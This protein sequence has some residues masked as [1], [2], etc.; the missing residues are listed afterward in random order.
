MVSVGGEVGIGVAS[1]RTEV[2]LQGLFLL[3]Q[4]AFVSLVLIQSHNDNSLTGDGNDFMVTVQDKV[5]GW[6]EC[7]SLF[8]V[9]PSQASVDTLTGPS[10]FN[11][12][13]SF[14]TSA[15]FGGGNPSQL[16][17]A[18]TLLFSFLDVLK[19]IIGL[20]V[21]IADIMIVAGW[22]LRWDFYW[23]IMPGQLRNW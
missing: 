4:I 2:T 12:F 14:F 18:V 17:S 7:K 15:A 10:A 20:M 3:F 16:F 21:A 9:A 8:C 6:P 22:I 11:T 13:S 5:I 19:G 1:V 23:G